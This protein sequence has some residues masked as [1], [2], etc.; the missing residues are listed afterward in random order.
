MCTGSHTNLEVIDDGVGLGNTFY[1]FTAQHQVEI[2]LVTVTPLHLTCC[3]PLCSA[4][5]RSHNPLHFACFPTLSSILSPTVLAALAADV[6]NTVIHAWADTAAVTALST[7][8]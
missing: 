3:C 7:T 1:P 4:A 2:P 5:R 8:V 6:G